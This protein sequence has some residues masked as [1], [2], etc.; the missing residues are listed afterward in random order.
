MKVYDIPGCDFVVEKMHV[1]VAKLTFLNFSC[2]CF[3]GTLIYLIF[4]T[5]ER[6]TVHNTNWAMLG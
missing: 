4:K 1:K 3:K 6:K 5:I 2:P